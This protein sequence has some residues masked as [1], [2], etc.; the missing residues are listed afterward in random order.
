MKVGLYGGTFDPIHMG[1]LLLAEWARDKFNLTKVIFVP[2]LIP[3][4]KQHH[5]I[6]SA[7]QRFE[8]V[9]LAI[10]GNPHFEVSNI[11]IKRK[12]V[13]YSIET[14]VKF[15]RRYQ[16]S[17]KQLYF[18][19][20]ADSLIEFSSWRTPRQILKNCQ[21]AV[22]RRSNFDV[23]KA[24]AEYLNNVIIIDNPLIDISSS[25]IR[26]RILKGK[27]IKYMVSPSVEEFISKSAIYKKNS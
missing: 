2:T 22:Y 20:G 14:I 7:H 6:T 27:S 18:L 3:P 9:R 11:E 8:M 15:R 24:E 26:E 16:L 23:S 12:D 1:H 13:S 17:K 21:V 25:D 10:Q 5:N 19:I 4:H